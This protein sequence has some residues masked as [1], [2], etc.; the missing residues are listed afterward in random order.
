MKLK[1]QIKLILCK[2]SENSLKFTSNIQKSN[3]IV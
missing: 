1:P 2:I 3:Q